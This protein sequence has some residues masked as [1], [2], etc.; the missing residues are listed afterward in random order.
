MDKA[1]QIDALLVANEL[2]R[3]LFELLIRRQFQ[4]PASYP[5]PGPILRRFFIHLLIDNDPHM[6]RVTDCDITPNCNCYHC[7]KPNFFNRDNHDSDP[8]ADAL[9]GPA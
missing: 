9:Y 2:L 5:L 8:D 1:E 3:P 6:A 7:T 4:L